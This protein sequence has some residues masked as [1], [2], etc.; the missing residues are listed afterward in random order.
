MDWSAQ[1]LAVL[2]EALGVLGGGDHRT[3]RLSA[4]EDRRPDHHAGLAVTPILW[5]GALRDHRQVYRPFLEIAGPASIDKYFYAGERTKGESFANYI[6]NKEVSRQEMESQLQEKVN[7]RVAGRVLLRQANLNDFQRE[8]IALKDQATLLTFD[9]VAAMLRPL[10]RP[11]LLAQAAGATLGQ[12]AAKHYPVMNVEYNDAEFDD[13]DQEEVGLEGQQA[14]EYESDFSSEEWDKTSS[15]LKTGPMTKKKPST[16]RHTAWRT[17]TSG[18]IFET[19]ERSEAS[20]NTALLEVATVNSEDKERG[21]VLR[22]DKEDLNAV[23]PRVAVTT[24]RTRGTSRARPR[25]WRQGQSVTTA[26]SWDT[27]LEI[28]PSKVVEKEPPT[29]K[30]TSL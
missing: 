21:L 11:E 29:R 24:K 4:Q 13:G 17:R 3:K 16:S 5:H 18:K 7:D 6:A 25:T 10:D 2:A 9:Q 20:S 23:V 22:Q 19:E 27:S 15:T 28:V 8:M 12:T 14:Q 26:Q 30:S 1:H